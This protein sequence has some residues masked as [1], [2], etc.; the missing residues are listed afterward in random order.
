VIF[1]PITDA[2]RKLIVKAL[3]DAAAATVSLPSDDPTEAA[4][5]KIFIERCR[6][7]ARWVETSVLGVLDFPLPTGR[8]RAK[9]RPLP[10]ARGTS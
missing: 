4:E 1:T 2:Q 10:A 7:T 8:R 9:I 6:G 5:D 3:R